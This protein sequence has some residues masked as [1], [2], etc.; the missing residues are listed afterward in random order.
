MKFFDA[1]FIVTNMVTDNISKGTQTFFEG[2][3]KLVT[4]NVSANFYRQANES[5]KEKIAGDFKRIGNDMYVALDK[6]EAKHGY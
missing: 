3:S 4:K 1:I 2:V 6:Y 5:D